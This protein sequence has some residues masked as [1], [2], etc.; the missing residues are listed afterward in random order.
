MTHPMRSPMRRTSLIPILL[1]LCL[2]L[3]ATCRKPYQ[4]QIEEQEMKNLRA[5]LAAKL[6]EEPAAEYKQRKDPEGKTIPP[7]IWTRDSVLYAPIVRGDSLDLADGQQLTLYYALYARVNGKEVLLESNILPLMQKAKLVA[8]E[9]NTLPVVYT[10]GRT[11]SI[12]GL[13]IAY[14]QLA[15]G[16]GRAWVGIPSRLAY[17][18]RAVGVVPGDT[19]LYAYVE[20]IAYSGK[21]IEE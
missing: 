5:I 7:P 13:R 6:R 2:P 12:E 1:L 14:S 18:S 21:R 20:F 10:L 11:G 3:L 8:T 15:H 4:D 17:G 9:R 16:R 19:P